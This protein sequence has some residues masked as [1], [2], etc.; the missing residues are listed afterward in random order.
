MSN[1]FEIDVTLPATPKKVVTVAAATLIDADG[2]V[3]LYQQPEGKLCAGQWGFPGGKLE[4]GEA[5]EWALVREL[6][7]ELGIETKP[8]CFWPLGFVSHDYGEAHVIMLVYTCRVWQGVVRSLEGLVLQWVKPAD[9]YNIDLL[10]A[11]IP[12]IPALQ[13]AVA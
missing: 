3:L 2:R 12:L 8:S 13:Q 4:A 7:E 6:R 5:P 1:C 10:P 9:L 11:D